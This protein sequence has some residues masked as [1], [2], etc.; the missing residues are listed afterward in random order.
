MNGKHI[1][2]DKNQQIEKLGVLHVSHNITLSNSASFYRNVSHLPVPVELYIES[3]QLI[4][5]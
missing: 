3:G 5:G 2:V 1:K 4:V